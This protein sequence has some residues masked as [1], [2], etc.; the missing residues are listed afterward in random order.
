MARTL[1]AGFRDEIESTNGQDVLVIF[2]TITH[3]SLEV[4]FYVNSDVADYVYGG[5]TF[6]GTGFQLSFLSDD[7]NPPQAKATIPNVDRR[8][9][10]ALLAISDS[11]QIKI[12][13]LVKSDFTDALPRQPI[14]TPLPE[15][16][17]PLLFLRNTQWDAQQMTADIF[18]YDI[19]SEPW[20][21]IRTTPTDT[22]ALFR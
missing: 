6:L 13:L 22:P 7:E 9:G 17:A 16:V 11:P 2:A 18:S 21:K 5:N 8:I 12:E 3:A 10:A 4:P 15:Y 20:P 19:T 14:G 1:T